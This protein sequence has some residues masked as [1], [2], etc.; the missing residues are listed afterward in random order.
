MANK[1]L[2]L[3][4]DEDDVREVLAL[5]LRGAGY[6]VDAV[7]TAAEANQRLQSMR[8]ALVIAGWRL[9]DGNGIDLADQALNLRA[10]TII[11][12]GYLFSLPAGAA[13]RHGTLMKPIRTNE[14]VTAVERSIGPSHRE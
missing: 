5:G 11:I 6:P 1:R 2:L 4:E 9:P 10:K 14:M 13:L 7:A 8:Y 3:V 12:S